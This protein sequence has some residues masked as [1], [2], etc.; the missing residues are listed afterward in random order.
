M[1]RNI[2]GLPLAVGIVALVGCSSGVW[3]FNGHS[4]RLYPS[5]L[6]SSTQYVVYYD[7]ALGP[8]YDGFWGTDGIFYFRTAADQPFQQDTGGHFR[9]DAANGFAAVNGRIA[10]VPPMPPLAAT[11]PQQ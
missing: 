9:R 4:S 3:P 6:Y 7:N 5:R 1:K 10:N 2:S 8:F 11:T